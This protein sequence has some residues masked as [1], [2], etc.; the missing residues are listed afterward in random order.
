M[1]TE[2]T[3]D[4]RGVVPSDDN[5]QHP[6]DANQ[7]VQH[8]SGGPIHHHYHQQ[9]EI[10]YDP[11]LAPPPQPVH[12]LPPNAAIPV[13][14]GPEHHHHHHQ[15]QQPMELAKTAIKM[16]PDGQPKP[17]VKRIFQA[18]APCRSRKAKVRLLSLQSRLFSNLES[19]VRRR[20]P[21]M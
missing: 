4:H 11:A 17:K 3:D 8:A 9:H 6:P 1:S 14:G 7:Q 15:E 2:P 5:G 21:I 16:G 12:Y 18:C 19:T 13:G 20:A 10:Q